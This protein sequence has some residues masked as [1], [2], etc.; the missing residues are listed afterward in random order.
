VVVHHV[1]VHEVR[2]RREHAAHFFTE[3]REIG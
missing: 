3:T 2:A 1:E